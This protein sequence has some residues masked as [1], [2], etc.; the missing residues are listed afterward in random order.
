MSGRVPSSYFCIWYEISACRQAQS[1][2]EV[3][4]APDWKVKGSGRVE[5]P[6]P[7]PLGRDGQEVGLEPLPFVEVI[8]VTV[9]VEEAGGREVEVVVLGG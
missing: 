4:L 7:S 8:E 6:D 5:D 3:T 1:L 9:V 2:L